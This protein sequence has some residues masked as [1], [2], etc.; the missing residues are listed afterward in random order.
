[1][2]SQTFSRLSHIFGPFSISQTEHVFWGVGRSMGNDK[3]VSAHKAAMKVVAPY[4]LIN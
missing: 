3:A 4:L 1:M 2:F